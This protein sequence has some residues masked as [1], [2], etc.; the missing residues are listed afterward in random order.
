MVLPTLYLSDGRRYPVPPWM[1]AVAKKI[2]EYN[3]T[4]DPKVFISR[5][6]RQLKAGSPTIKL[7]G[8]LDQN[9]AK[10]FAKA[11]KEEIAWLAE[12]TKVSPTVIKNAQ[13]KYNALSASERR[14]PVATEGQLR[15]FDKRTAI[16]QDILKQIDNKGITSKEIA[17]NLGM[18][19][20]K[21]LKESEKL[22]KNVY[23]EKMH[24]I[25][26]HGAPKYDSN[27]TYLSYINP[28]AP[29]GGKLKFGVCR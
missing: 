16:Q 21:L 26:M 25:A 6:E 19:H 3:K 18:S 9:Q 24:G 23:A 14:S 2:L 10:A 27:F 28:N 5:A 11:S 15:A 22:F 12:K 7:E 13:T 8:F 20:K 29:K 1:E 4:K 17:K